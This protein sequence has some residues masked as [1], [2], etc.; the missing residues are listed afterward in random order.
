MDPGVAVMIVAGASLLL[1]GA[2]SILVAWAVSRW[3][4]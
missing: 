3:R 4:P 1:V 2:G